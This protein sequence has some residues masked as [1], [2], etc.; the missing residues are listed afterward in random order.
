[1]LAAARGALY[2]VFFVGTLRYVLG[3]PAPHS[4]DQQTRDFTTTAMAHSYGRTLILLVGIVIGAI[5]LAM[6]RIGATKSFLED[7]QLSRASRRTREGVEL[8]GTIG[9]LAR[10]LVFAGVGAFMVDASVTCNASKAKG[11]DATLR[12]FAHT[13]VGPLLLVIV[14]I[15]LAL[16]RAYSLAKARW[17]R[18]I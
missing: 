5:G 10:G 6:V 4:T 1:M 9:N 15:G 16:F 12:S 17:H 13:P 7:L 2:T 18:K 8:V 14:A 11:I 3:L